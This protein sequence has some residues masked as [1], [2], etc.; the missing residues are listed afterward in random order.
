MNLRLYRSICLVALFTVQL[1]AAESPSEPQFESYPTKPDV[2][3][4]NAEVRIAGRME[5]SYITRL[6]FAAKQKPNF[7]GHYILTAWGCGAACLVP[8]AIDAKTGVVVWLNFSVCCWQLQVKEPLEF[9]LNSS[10]LI[11][12]GSRN[13]EGQGTYYYLL[14]D[15]EF[16]LLKAEEKPS[17]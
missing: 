7:A 13:V 10:L 1:C 16:V 6:R 8:V 4:K 11:V 9:K 17:E 5:R 14:K 15:Q 12:R 3:T 2:I